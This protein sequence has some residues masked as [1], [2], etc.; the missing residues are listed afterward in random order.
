MSHTTAFHVAPLRGFAVAQ[1]QPSPRPTSEF[2]KKRVFAIFE[3]LNREI[4]Q[5]QHGRLG[6][7]RTEVLSIVEEA[8]GDVRASAG[9]IEEAKGHFATARL[10]LGKNEPWKAVLDDLEAAII[11]ILERHEVRISALEKQVEFEKGALD[12]RQL[13]YE[14]QPPFLA[15]F[16]PH[17]PSH[18]QAAGS[19]ARF[20]EL[21]DAQ[22]AALSQLTPFF[23]LIDL[24]G[25]EGGDHAHWR[26]N[27][28]AAT[29]KK[30]IVE[31]DPGLAADVDPYL[32]WCNS[33][34]KKL[35]KIDE[36]DDLFSAGGI[37]LGT[38][39]RRAQLRR[40]R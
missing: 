5:N 26:R 2:Y 13:S 31:R 15:Q 9:S 23:D 10:R 17:L 36:S 35:G 40:K 28:T 11:P 30:L 6:Q 16:L 18:L 25:V 38:K 33:T 20:R 34:L 14:M 29:L 3:S 32:L 27:V 22:R 19:L 12:L 1:A 8:A 7:A 37:S 24:F 4:P 39:D 21:T